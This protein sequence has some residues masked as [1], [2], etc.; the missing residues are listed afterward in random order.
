MSGVSW[1]H[2]TLKSTLTDRMEFL[3]EGVANGIASVD[4]YRAMC[5]RYHE[6]KRMLEITIPEIFTDFYQAEE[7]EDEELG[8][9]D[10]E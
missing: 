1:L 9:L 10:E 5:G 2:D 3:K 6:A 4:E 7:T 8:E